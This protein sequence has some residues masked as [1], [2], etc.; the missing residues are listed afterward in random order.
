MNVIRSAYNDA[1]D[2][3]KSSVFLA[4]PTHRKDVEE[5]YKWRNEAIKIFSGFHYEGNL[6]IPE[7]FAGDYKYQIAWEEK[8]LEMATVIM[9]WI[10]RD[11]EELPA[12]TTN[13]EFGEWMKSGKVVLGYP[14]DAVH[15]NYLRYKAEKYGIP[16]SHSIIDTIAKV[17]DLLAKKI[18]S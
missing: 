7:P 4:G 6:F 3:K 18:N 16:I 11:M 14:K 5:K 1:S 9:F 17:I 2:D 13:I 15:M 8:H 10:P 12:L